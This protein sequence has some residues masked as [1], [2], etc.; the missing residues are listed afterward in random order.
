MTD[1]V[2]FLSGERV[3]HL[4]DGVRDLTSVRLWCPT[5]ERR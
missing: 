3:T 2:L 1:D 5:G 4:T